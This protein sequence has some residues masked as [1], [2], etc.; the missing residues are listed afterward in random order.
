HSTASMQIFNHLPF[1]NKHMKPNH[2]KAI[3]LPVFILCSINM[4]AYLNMNCENSRKKIQP[5][6]ENPYPNIAAIPVPDGYVRIGVDKS[7]FGNWLRG[8]PLKK[9]KTVYLYNGMKKE[10][11]SAQF[12]VIDISTGD[13]DLQQC[14]DA[15]M[16]FRAEYLFAQCKFEEIIFFD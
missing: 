5:R 3:I 6:N 10:D 4:A 2:L 8:L 16:R 1:K 14:A 12:A 15:V 11:Q 7:S 13:K 9:N